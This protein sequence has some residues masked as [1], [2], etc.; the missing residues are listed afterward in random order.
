MA[1]CRRTHVAG[2]RADPPGTKALDDSDFPE[3]ALTAVEG[4]P[5]PYTDDVP[6]IFG[7]YWCNPEFMILGPTTLCVDFSAGKGGPLAAYR[8]DGEQML[9]E[10]KL[11]MA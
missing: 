3:L 11:V 8:W 4:V 2:R 10:R 1:R 9:D 7:H 6:V 5:A